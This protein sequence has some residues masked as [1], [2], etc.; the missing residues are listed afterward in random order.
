MKTITTICA[1]LLCTICT[2]YANITNTPPNNST[3]IITLTW[4][5]TDTNT[6]G[7][8]YMGSSSRNYTTNFYVTTNTWS[9]NIAPNSIQFFAVTSAN[10]FG[11]Q[12]DF[13]NEIGIQRGKPAAPFLNRY[14]ITI[15]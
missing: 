5:W 12:S 6:C 14:S 2:S 8:V 4:D 1:L 3:N 10:P 13:S 9:T 11:D 7:Y 15:K